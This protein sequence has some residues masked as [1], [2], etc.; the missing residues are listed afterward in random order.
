LKQGFYHAAQSSRH[1][2]WVRK[3][4]HYSLC[5]C[6]SVC[7]WIGKSVEGREVKGGDGKQLAYLALCALL[8]MCA[9]CTCCSSSRAFVAR[10]TLACTFPP[11]HFASHHPQLNRLL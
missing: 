1:E 9:A 11:G 3:L 8:A 4:D 2:L 5:I 6:M 10:W 7:V